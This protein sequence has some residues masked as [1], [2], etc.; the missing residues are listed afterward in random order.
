MLYAKIDMIGDKIMENTK[1]QSAINSTVTKFM[2][3]FNI[4]LDGQ[5]NKSIEFNNG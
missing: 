5:E 4:I 1:R 3:T 2:K